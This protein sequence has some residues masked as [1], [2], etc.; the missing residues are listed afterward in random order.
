MAYECVFEGGAE[1]GS[2]AVVAREMC[3][4]LN[5]VRTRA[6]WRRPS[7]LL[8]HR[9]ELERG[10]LAVAAADVQLPDLGLATG[11]GQLEV[12]VAAVDLPELRAARDAAAI[13]V[14]PT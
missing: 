8:R 13:V 10:L 1:V 2:L 12:A 14:W 6:L 11:D 4:R 3:V 7:I 5:D 9:W